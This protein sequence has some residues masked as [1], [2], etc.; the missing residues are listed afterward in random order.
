VAVSDRPRYRTWIRGTRLAV[1]AAL[2]GVCL[3]I[4]VAKPGNHQ[5]AGR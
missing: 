1:L 5:E 3:V 4:V 2:S